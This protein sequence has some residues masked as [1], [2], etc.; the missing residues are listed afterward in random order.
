MNLVPAHTLPS[1]LGAIWPELDLFPSAHFDT[2]ETSQCPQ[3]PASKWHWQI[4][5]LW[6]RILPSACLS[7]DVTSAW[8]TVWRG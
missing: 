5:I 6:H 4:L 8:G 7:P 3:Q 2:S 1:L